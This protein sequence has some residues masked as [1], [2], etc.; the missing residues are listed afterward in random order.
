MAGPTLPMRFPQ[1]LVCVLIELGAGEWQLGC[2][3]S[4]HPLCLALTLAHSRYPVGGIT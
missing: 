4:L 1:F 3:L 2:L